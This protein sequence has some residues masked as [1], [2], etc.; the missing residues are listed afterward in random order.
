VILVFQGDQ[1]LAQ[2]SL[3]F[4]RIWDTRHGFPLNLTLML[5]LHKITFPHS[6]Q[7][8]CEKRQYNYNLTPDKK[9]VIRGCLNQPHSCPHRCDKKLSTSVKNQSCNCQQ[10]F[11]QVV[12]KL[13]QQ[14]VQKSANKLSQNY[15]L[16]ALEINK[17]LPPRALIP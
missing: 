13:C 4:A 3:S 10:I 9:S 17:S 6:F 14:V 16:N 12:H 5:K 2:S 15:P 1:L 8:R 11:P 7:H